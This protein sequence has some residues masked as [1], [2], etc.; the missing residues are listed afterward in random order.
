MVQLAI[1]KAFISK[2]GHILQG[3]TYSFRAIRKVF[4]SGKTAEVEKQLSVAAQT[5][6]SAAKVLEPLQPAGKDSGLTSL[7]N[8]TALSHSNNVNDDDDDDPHYFYNY[9]IIIVSVTI[10]K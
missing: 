5:T 9:N 4:S 8:N 3:S 10:I 6:F 7:G 1:E 2:C